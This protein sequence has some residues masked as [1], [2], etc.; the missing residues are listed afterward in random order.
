MA[1]RR[2][3]RSGRERLCRT[4]LGLVRSALSLLGA[5]AYNYPYAYYPY[6]RGRYWGGW[7]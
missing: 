5:Y 7:Y 1:S 6:W 4:T 2:L 3:G